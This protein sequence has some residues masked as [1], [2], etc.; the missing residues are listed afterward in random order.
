MLAGPVLPVRLN[1]GTP[2]FDGH[3]CPPAHQCE[4]QVIVTAPMT[5]LLMLFLVSG[6]ILIGISLPLI[7]GRVR[8]NRWYGFRVGR[9]LEDPKVWYLVNSY[10]GW[11]LLASGVA[12]IVVATALYFVPDLD[13][14]VYASIVGVVA[15]AGVMIGLVQSFRY[16]HQVTKE[17]EAATR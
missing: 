14:D 12:E 1:S 3:D 2:A 13:V 8:P 9:T 10:S 5:L 15:V 7:Q 11:R 6:A 4:R 16:L 17:R